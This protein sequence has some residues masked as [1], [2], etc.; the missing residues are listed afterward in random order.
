MVDHILSDSLLTATDKLV[1]ISILY[2][3]KD[4]VVIEKNEEIATKINS[5]ITSV[6]RSLRNLSENKYIKIVLLHHRERQ[7]ICLTKLTRH[8]INLVRLS[9]NED[10]TLP[11]TQGEPTRNLIKLTRIGTYL[12][13]LIRWKKEQMFKD[14]DFMTTVPVKLFNSKEKRDILYYIYIY[15]FNKNKKEYYYIEYDENKIPKCRFLH[16]KLN[17]YNRENKGLYPVEMYSS[18]LLHYSQPNKKGVPRWFLELT[19]KNGS[20]HI[21]GRLAQWSGRGYS[22]KKNESN[23]SNGSNGKGRVV[24]TSAPIDL[25][26]SRSLPKV[27]LD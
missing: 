10:F 15:Y 1:A 17:Q 21:P 2:M 22:N 27:E 9:E 25:R 26:G 19:K 13:R 6:S 12:I 4:G 8:L 16:E 7:I 23:G 20:F 24:S 3:V 11:K 18:F 5:N 14:Q